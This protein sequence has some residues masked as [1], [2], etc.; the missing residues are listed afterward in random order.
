MTNWKY[1]E[2]VSSMF[3]LKGIPMAPALTF[4]DITIKSKWSDIE[5][6]KDITNLKARLGKDFYINLP[7]VSANM[8]DVTEHLMAI[9]LAKIGAI[10]FIHQFTTVEDRVEEIK[11]V[12]S[13]I[14]DEASLKEF[15]NALIDKQ[16][17]LCVAGTLRL[18]GDYLDE[19]KRFLEAGADV[20]VLDTARAG[21]TLAYNATLNIKK[22]FPN[23]I[24]IVGNID[25]PEH[26]EKLAEAGADCI[27]IG[28][29]PGSRCKTRMVTGVGTPQ[30]H[31]VISC[32]AV[33]KKLGVS[34]IADGGI[35]N[36]SDVAK[37][38]GA[39]ADAVMLGSLLAGAEEAP[40]LLVKKIDENGV[41]KLFKRYRGSASL[42]QQIDRIKNGN[43]DSAREPEGE[44]SDVPHIGPADLFVEKLINGLRSSMSY[45]GAH[46]LNEFKDKV[47]FLW[48]NNSGFEEGKPRMS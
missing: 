30:I 16:N 39:G 24:L 40:S 13:V 23:C 33:A 11:N 43:L 4:S 41:E 5:H 26:L 18:S 19:A 45:V 36:S 12:K 21:S 48:V 35:R 2:D 44:T 10:G 25:N 31:A 22:D 34:I 1:Q 38:L 28:V 47:E 37:A 8:S 14:M 29:G 17:R 42:D 15:P 20:L 3:G 9:A 6:R 7:I 27:K 46:D 32:Y